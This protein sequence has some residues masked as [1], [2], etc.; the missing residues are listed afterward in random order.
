MHYIVDVTPDR[1]GNWL[2]ELVFWLL[3]WPNIL[4]GE[5]FIKRFFAAGKKA[6]V[7]TG[8]VHEQSKHFTYKTCLIDTNLSMETRT[9][10]T[11]SSLVMYVFYK[12]YDVNQQRKHLTI[13]MCGLFVA[14]STR[15]V[16]EQL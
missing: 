4:C 3:M 16:A 13:E 11:Y 7:T 6:F 5:F 14:H 1:N 10:N 8:I 12:E 2:H 9:Y 15:A